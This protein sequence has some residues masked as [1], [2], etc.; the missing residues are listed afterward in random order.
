MLFFLNNTIR[1]IYIYVDCSSLNIVSRLYE[2]TG[3][4]ER[5]GLIV[6]KTGT[7]C[8]PG[9]L[10]FYGMDFEILPVDDIEEIKLF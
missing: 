4:Q 1:R 8:A 3:E 6:T 9:Y 5:C 2:S 7:P 10:V